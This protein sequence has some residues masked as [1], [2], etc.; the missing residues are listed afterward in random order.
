M[1]T[2]KLIIL[3]L[4]IPIVLFAENKHIYFVVDGSGSMEGVPL[5]EAK[6]SMQNIAKKIFEDGEKIAL[7]VGKD[8]CGGGT[9]VATK[10]F[11][12]MKEL[13]KALALIDPTGGHNITL[14]FEYAQEK[15]KNN[16]YTGHIYMFG[17]CDGLEH[18]RSIKEISNKYKK[19]N[20]FTPFTYLEVDG[21]TNQEKISWDT[22]LKDIGAKIGLASTFDYKK[23]ISKK[24]DVHKKYFTESK[25]INKDATLNEGNNFSQKPWRC[26]ESDN[27][28]WLTITE[29]EQKLDF[30][31]TKPKNINRYK[32]NNHSVIVEEFINQL[33]SNNTC[34]KNDWRLPD[35]F[36]L[37]RLTQLGPDFREKRFPYI[38]IWAHISSTG[39]KYNNFKKGVDLN[40]G[41]SYDYR[42]DKPYASIF[43]SGDIDKTLFVAPNEL[44]DRY[45]IIN[46]IPT[47]I[48]TPI[49]TPTPF[50]PKKCTGSMVT[51][52]LCTKEECIALGECD[53]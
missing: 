50:L 46:P 4:L 42:E 17:D 25:F 5:Q 12:S 53:K 16:N 39:G 49:P 35:N 30:F 51:N 15:M 45:N 21:C 44:L 47:P 6:N 52:K 14:G 36:E 20:S 19:L 32:D 37:S 38:K 8:S 18:C 11:S 48:K 7:V 27:I 9:R 29:E 10:F 2:I 26:I 13:N 41:K 40:N 22:T 24:I 1:K 43:V 3:H 31:I 34:G 33:N 23:I 28:L